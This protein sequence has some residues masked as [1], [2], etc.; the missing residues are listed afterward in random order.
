M[1][2]IESCKNVN[3]GPNKKC[4]KRKGRPKCICAPECGA[5]V[6]RRQKMK[7]FKSATQPHLHH[8]HHHR[9]SE[10]MFSPV[11]R[12]LESAVIFGK[13]AR[14]IRSLSSE[15]QSQ[16]LGLTEED[17]E[18]LSQRKLS[19]MQSGEGGV[20]GIGGQIKSPLKG[21]VEIK[22]RKRLLIVEDRGQQED[23]NKPTTTRRLQV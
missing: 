7:L 4:A 17:V 14:D 2:S 23:E 19:I 11:Q 10:S 22:K 12:N 21:G 16:N 5:A 18:N 20:G 8:H 15:I 3:C 6:R 1:V 13:S 9:N